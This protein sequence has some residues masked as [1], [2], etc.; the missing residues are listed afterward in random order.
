MKKKLSKVILKV[1]KGMFDT[2]APN[3]TPSMSEKEFNALENKTQTKVDWVRII[4][5]F[6]TFALLVLN[7][8][9]QIN[10]TNFIKTLIRELSNS[11]L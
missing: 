4:S 5:A 8:F 1:I 11:V 3:I 10:I 6:I 7:F 2:I 9:G